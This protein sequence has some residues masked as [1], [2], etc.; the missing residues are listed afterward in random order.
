M[1]SAACKI[2]EVVEELCGLTKAVAAGM[3]KLSSEESATK[4]QA[5]IDSGKQVVVGVNKFKNPKEPKID[6][7]VIDNEKVREDQIIKI[8]NLKKNRNPKDL[9]D[10]LSRITDMA[11]NNSGNLL[12]LSIEAIRAR[13]TVGEVSKALEDA[14]GRHYATNVG[15]S[16]VYGKFFEKDA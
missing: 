7:L 15:V 11:K 16:G 1:C 14:F 13:A 5:K 6:V 9:E 2:I 8:T 3:P 12:A 10:C 4:K